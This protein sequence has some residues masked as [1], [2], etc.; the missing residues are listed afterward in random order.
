MAKIF[1]CINTLTSVEQVLYANHM[2]FFFK[3]G[4]NLGQEHQFILH[5]P[6]RHSIDRARNASAKMALE[7]NCDYLMFI[8]DDVVVPVDILEK[9][10]A[11]DK[12]IIAGWTIIRGWPF[13]NMFF[14]YTE[15][16]R[17][18]VPMPDVKRNSGIIDVDAIGFSTALIKCSVIK[19]IPPPWFVTGPT[20]TEDIYFCLK[21]KQYLPNVSICVDTSVETA[22]MLGPEFISPWNRENYKAYQLA[23]NPTIGDKPI[24]PL[25]DKSGD[26]GKAYLDMARGPLADRRA[27]EGH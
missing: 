1:I 26:R 7:N 10:L 22:H 5:T 16:T 14:K 15:G 4:K 27:Y 19:Q 6:R 3:L 9:L 12:D 20:N 21:A 13:D 11:A 23:E 18:L 2:S 24:P 25:L 17:N 8:D